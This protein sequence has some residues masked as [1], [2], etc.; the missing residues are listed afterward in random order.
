[1]TIL[2]KMCCVIFAALLLVGTA[3]AAKAVVT[4][5]AVSIASTARTEIIFFIIITSF[6]L[7]L[8]VSAVCLDC[9][10]IITRFFLLVFEIT[11]L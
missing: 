9:D 6:L 3:S 4:G 11:K 5:T 7:E 8:N 10:H 2:K 1:M